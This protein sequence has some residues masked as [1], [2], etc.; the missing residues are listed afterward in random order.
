[1]IPL[2]P[3]GPNRFRLA[4]DQHLCV[5]HPD[6]QFLFGGAG[7][8]A[9]LTAIETVTGRPT[10]WAAAQYLSYAR[11][12]T[13]LDL[14]VTVPVTG[15]YTSQARVVARARNSDGGDAEIITVNAALGVRPGQP[16]AQWAVMPDV[17]A[18]EACPAFDYDWTRRPD[19][20]NAGFD[21]RV[22]KG[23]FGK[24]RIDTEPSEDG[25]ARLW[26][27][28]ASGIV[29]RTSLALMADFLP[30]G[31]GNALGTAAGG[32]SLDNTIRF[33]RLVPTTWVLADI[34]IH[35]TAQGFAH[36]SAHLFAEDGTLLATASQSLILRIR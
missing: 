34:R 22:A 16:E 14:E 26:I 23:R 5:G 15:K 29:D 27:R 30:S 10:V 6:N 8:A 31:V 1:M 12:G 28:P 3:L 4:V 7:M 35:A 20:V 2:E 18:P 17:P 36:G 11:P 24:A 25:I 13:T 19:D 33:A 32:N 9:G 21:K